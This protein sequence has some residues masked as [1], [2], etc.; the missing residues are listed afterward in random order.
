MK[1]VGQMDRDALEA[2]V[3]FWRSEFGLQRDAEFERVLTEGCGLTLGQA[4]I[5]AA[6]YGAKGRV[7]TRFQIVEAAWQSRSEKPTAEAVSVLLSIAHRRTGIRWATN[8]WGRGYVI[9]HAGRDA[10]EE[11]M[12]DGRA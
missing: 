10:I 5:V 8:V 1:P 11:K 2:E 4:R 3:L 7:L 6:L 12:A 9:S